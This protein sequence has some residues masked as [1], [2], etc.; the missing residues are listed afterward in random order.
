MYWIITH[1]KKSGGDDIKDASFGSFTQRNL[2]NEDTRSLKF[3][4]CYIDFKCKFRL[5]IQFV[6]IFFQEEPCKL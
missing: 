3:L 2:V 4:S 6:S 5:N 1:L